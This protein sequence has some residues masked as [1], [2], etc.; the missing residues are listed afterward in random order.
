MD[1]LVEPLAGLL[2][3]L[4]AVL[5]V[6]GGAAAARYRD[7]RL[8]FISAAFVAL[9][10][11]GGLAFLHVVSPR[12]GEPYEVAPIPLGLALLSSILVY[13]AMVR[14]RPAPPPP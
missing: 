12:Y 5:A 14:G 9:A 11:I 8:A 7:P 3:G 13:V 6:L 1:Y 2:T 4:A 10:T